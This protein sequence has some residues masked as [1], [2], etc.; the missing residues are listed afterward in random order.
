MRRTSS[1]VLLPVLGLSLLML[2][3][4]SLP[5]S[6]SVRSMKPTHVKGAMAVFN[7]KSLR[8]A[9]VH[10]AQLRLGREKRRISARTVRNAA[11]KGTLRLRLPGR[12]LK[13]R[14][15]TAPISR[16]SKPR[17]VVVIREA[18]A[19]APTPPPVPAGGAPRD[20]ASGGT[21][22][23]GSSGSSSDS[24]SRGSAAGSPPNP[25]V[26]PPAAPPV[27]ITG[28]A[29]YVSSSG[30]DSNPGTSP[31]SA[32]RTV[33]R[34]NRA[35]LNPGDGVLFE[36]GASFSDDTL[37]P[38]RSGASGSPIVY[39]SYGTGKATLTKGVW[40]SST[41][42]LAFT[43]LAISGA[44]QGVVASSNGSGSTNIVVQNSSFTNVGIGVNAAN[45][46]DR[47]WTVRSNNVDG[48]RDSGVIL[49]G[50][51]HVAQSNTILHTGTDS[52]IPYGKHGIYLKSADSRVT[53]NT[54]RYFQA[55]GVSSR[56][57]NAVIENNTISDGEVGIAWYQ[58]DPQAGVSFWRN[59]EV[60]RTTAASLYVSPSDAAGNTRE[61][62]V[63]T[64]NQL[65][66]SAG[67][68]T[69]FQAT[70][71]VYTILDNILR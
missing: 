38:P 41:S 62:F 45:D 63:V 49:Q 68:Y 6:A 37:M 56:Y 48:S 29:F 17:L 42:W 12:W 24:G 50:A 21:G 16:R 35:G 51:G 27:A 8:S 66:K 67:R 65:A 54:I 52:S 31:S 20:R 10:S 14:H 11:R 9:K 53:G 47:N 71:G 18:S 55:E 19:A 46:A 64:G 30:S 60:A 61:S 33:D 40:F 15:R 7:I 70:S 43:D 69:D 5:A 4:G 36:G 32:W 28:R 57:R 22:S 13:A 1:R 26:A 34:A 59:N 2:M 44:N 3:V 23:S 25:P 39:G 58:S